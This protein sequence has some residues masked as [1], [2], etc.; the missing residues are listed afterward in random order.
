MNSTA[1]ACIAFLGV[2][3]FGLGL[4]VSVMRFRD[5]TVSGHSGDPGN[6]LHKLVRAHGNTAEYAPFLAVLFLY[7]GLHAPSQKTQLLM[8]AATI[9]RLLL[10]I[11]LVGGRSMD[12]P[13]PFRFVG[14]LGTY[15]LGLTLCAVAAFGAV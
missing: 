7:L 6:R 11:G 8:V 12:T 2:L 9:C 10:V 14:A 13:N 5:G 3:L 4:L 15:L 1:L